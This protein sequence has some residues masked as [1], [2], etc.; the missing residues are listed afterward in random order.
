MRLTAAQLVVWIVNAVFL[1]GLAASAE[2]AP[3]TERVLDALK[4][5]PPD[6]KSVV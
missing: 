5:I 3:E 1:L 4:K 6:R 2:A